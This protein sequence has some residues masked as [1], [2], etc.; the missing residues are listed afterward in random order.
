VDALLAWLGRDPS[1]T[2][3]TEIWGAVLSEAIDPVF[4]AGFYSFWLGGRAERLSS[5]YYYVLNEAH[6]GYL[7]VYLNGG[8]VGV[9]LLVLLLG[10]SAWHLAGRVGK[11]AA[12]AA[13]AEAFRL[14]LVIVAIVYNFSEAVA[15]RLDAIWLTALLVVATPP[16]LRSA[17][18]KKASVAMAGEV[19]YR[20]G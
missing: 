11:A 20:P 19:R 10:T 9:S 5:Q 7:E 8:L 4:G 1:L 16:R 15:S 17:A 18:R 13:G 6:N 12:P 2:G 3:R 14:A